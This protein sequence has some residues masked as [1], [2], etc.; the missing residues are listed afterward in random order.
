MEGAWTY[1]LLF[2]AGL[3]A[4]TINVLAGGGSFLTLPLLIFVGLPPTI[5]NA[6][7]RVG[8]FLQN[9]G[10]VWG[11][12]RHGVLDWRS[13][14]WAAVPAALGS[15]LGT[16]AALRVGDDAFQ[17]VLAFLMIAVTLWSL[18]NPL[19][20]RAAKGGGGLRLGLLAAGFFVVGIYGGFV[21]AGVGFFILAATTLAGLDLVRGNAV[22]VLSVLILTSMSL[23]I[24]AWQGKVDW[25]LGFAL[26]AGNTVGGFIGVRLAVLGG[27]EWLRKVVTASV[28]FFALML[29]LRG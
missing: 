1:P 5:A 17:R 27:H 15:V 18:W 21:Q 3:I 13:F 8:V 6:T 9:V 20:G 22:K 11:F 2:G 29:L 28:L 19:K 24:F 4:G 14:C 10:A 12:H 16:W 26:G 25:I 7:N 23:G